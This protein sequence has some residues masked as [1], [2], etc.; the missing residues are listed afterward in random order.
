MPPKNSCTPQSV[1]GG[2]TQT[3]F[4]GMSVIDFSATAGWN[5]QASSVTVKLVV[6]ECGGPRNYFDDNFNWKTNINFPAGDPGFNN[7]PI[8][9]A[10]FFKVE[11]FEF[12]GLI[13]SYNAT[14]DPNGN[15]VLLVT[16][17]SP[18]QLLDGAQVITDEYQGSVLGMPNVFNVYGWLESR[19]ANCPE[20]GGFGAPAGGF[21]FARRNDRG[22]PWILAKQALQ[23]LLGGAETSI[24]SWHGGITYKEGL[25]ANRYGNIRSEGYVVDITDLP[26]T[27]DIY[28]RLTNGNY[29]LSQLISEVCQDGGYE[30]YVDLIPC[31]GGPTSPITNVIK[32][33]TVSRRSQ[34]A[35]GEIASFIASTN[36]GAAGKV[37]TQNSIGEELRLDSPNSAFIVGAKKEQTYQQT[38]TSLLAPFWGFNDDGG[39]HVGEYDASPY[40]GQWQVTL[41]VRSL[42]LSLN[43][44]FASTSV[45]LSEST[46]CA[47]QGLSQDHFLSWLQQN[48]D[49]G[50]L[51]TYFFTTLSLVAPF[52]FQFGAAE[53]EP[54]G[55]ANRPDGR[56]SRD[57][58]APAATDAQTVYSWLKSYANQVYG[59]Q[60]LVAVPW[61]CFTTDSDTGQILWS[62]EPNSSAWPNT[63]TSVLGLT[64]PST[65]TD[66]F[67]EENG[68]LKTFMRFVGALDTSL[69]GSDDYVTDG[70]SIWVKGEVNEKWVITPST[71]FGAQY[72]AALVTLPNRVTIQP[73]VA[74][75]QTLYAGENFRSA[76]VPSNWNPKVN[77]G[78]IS[79]P[80]SLPFFAPNGAAVAVKSNTDTYGP[81]LATASDLIVNGHPFGGKIYYEQDDGLSPWEYGGYTYMNLGATAKIGNSITNETVSERGAVTVAGYPEK[82]LGLAITDSPSLLQ[83][84]VLQNGSYVGSNFNYVNTGGVSTKACQITNINVT[85][86]SSAVTTQYQI[87]SFTPVFGRFSKDN[88][89]RMKQIGQNRLQF[90]RAAR[91]SALKR[92]LVN[93]GAALA[94]IS[95]TL[96]M[97]SIL[98]QSDSHGSPGYYLHGKQFN[99]GRRNVV[100]TPSLTEITFYDD[101]DNTA[102]MTMDGFFKPVQKRSA[103]SSLPQEVADPNNP[104]TSTQPNYTEAPPPPLNEY[105]PMRVSTDYLDFLANPSSSTALRSA[106]PASGHNVEGVARGTKTSYDNQTGLFSIAKAEELGEFGY[107]NDYRYLAHRGP[108]VVHGWGYDLAGKPVPNS[109]IDSAGSWQSSYNNLTNSFSDAWL[110][111]DKLWPTAPIDLRYDRRR[112]VWTV[113]PGFRMYKVTGEPISAGAT[114]SVIVLNAADVYDD[115]GSVITDKTINVTNITDTAT[116]SGQEYIAYYD[117]TSNSYWPIFPGSGGGGSISVAF[118]PGDCAT[119]S[120]FSCTG[121]DCLEF[122]RGFEITTGNGTGTIDSIPLH[123]VFSGG[124]QLSDLT[125]MGYYSGIAFSGFKV[126][127]NTQDACIVEIIADRL[128]SD[129]DSCAT[130]QGAGAVQQEFFKELVFGSGMSV[131]NVDD[132]HYIDSYLLADGLVDGADVDVQGTK[133]VNKI[134]FDDC[135]KAVYVDNCNLTLSTDL[136]VANY[137]PCLGEAAPPDSAYTKFCKLAFGRGLLASPAGTTEI[138]L[139]FTVDGNQTTA[140]NFQNV[141]NGDFGADTYGIQ[142]VNSPAGCT[143]TVRG[144]VEHPF[145]LTVDNLLTCP[146]VPVNNS[147]DSIEKITFLDGFDVTAGAAN[148][149]LVKT[150]HAIDEGIVWPWQFNVNPPNCSFFDTLTIGRGLSVTRA[151]NCDSVC[152]YTIESAFLVSDVGTLC[153]GALENLIYRNNTVRIDA[154]EFGDYMTLSDGP[155]DGIARVDICSPRVQ[156]WT[157][158]DATTLDPNDAVEY[159]LLQLSNIAFEGLRGEI[160]NSTDFYVVHEH[161]AYGGCT[162]FNDPNADTPYDEALASVGFKFQDLNF[163]ECFTVGK[164]SANTP[165]ADIGACT[166]D[167]GLCGKTVDVEVVCSSSCEGESR[168]D[169]T[170]TLEFKDGL[171]QNS[172]ACGSSTT[173]PDGDIINDGGGGSP[174]LAADPVIEFGYYDIVNATKDLADSFNGNSMAVYGTA[175]LGGITLT[176]PLASAVGFAAITITKTDAT[177]NII[178][179]ITAGADTFFDGSSSQDLTNQGEGYRYYSDGLSWFIA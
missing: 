90:G 135:L 175:A 107:A 171:L 27:T 102:L 103:A 140:I 11:N 148:E 17:V 96:Q 54:A 166:V 61:V 169:Q 177:A 49:T 66:F 21:G 41:D 25:T 35:L 83:S 114:S 132:V 121:F 64:F 111:N 15:P 101:F 160:R 131:I 71:I 46:L 172:S 167:I 149:V 70:T 100:T 51:A 155:F 176:L 108:L 164:S 117:N 14:A 137:D 3:L 9:S 88:A 20:V 18:V 16:L 75:G 138:N 134:T 39:L 50:D 120:A 99:T 92:S 174:G 154:I 158:E 76:A 129:E 115:Q 89:E 97:L 37:I 36:A 150:R 43:T 77:P 1:Y 67:A 104:T 119:G 144:Y 13:Q 165:N 147:F 98:N 173:N 45:N 31:K 38:S 91:A 95:S 112:G 109:G 126:Q 141:A 47:A 179:V 57:P 34:P 72:A 127:D 60:W 24:Y 30:Y 48:D 93:A 118:T 94:G 128:I 84:R 42:N 8:G 136:K 26:V 78:A 113:P 62:D 68:K 29:T 6:D 143:T 130:L 145:N 116:P 65:Y 59:K 5:E 170:L 162:R 168:N 159:N 139:D 124:G 105:T 163:S 110:Q 157:C 53:N 151:D 146:L 142:W 7:A 4:L 52:N 156:A 22:I 85:V 86:G 12:A 74:L 122:G 87:S 178:S 153:P 79:A 161:Y 152:N 82:T 125:H 63:L 80:G 40:P 10:A 44:P 2:Y 69:L 55:D 19:D 58:K 133:G 73:T 56:A 106:V 28:Y 123:S 33:R 81:W 23:V 32:I